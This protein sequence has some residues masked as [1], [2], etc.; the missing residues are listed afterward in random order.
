ML[1]DN[2]LERGL[3]LALAAEKASPVEGLGS[4]ELPHVMAEAAYADAARL[5]AIVDDLGDRQRLE[6]KLQRLQ[7]T[8]RLL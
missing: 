5:L 6:W 3:H 8:L 1:I 2:E 4:A 7:Q